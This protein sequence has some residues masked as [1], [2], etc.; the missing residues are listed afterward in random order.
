MDTVID[1]YNLIRQ[2]PAL[3]TIEGRGLEAGREA[4]LDRLFLYKSGG[5]QAMT[6]VF[7]GPENRGYFARGGI[8]VQFSPSADDAVVALAGPG[9]LVVSSDIEVQTDAR[10]RGARVQGAAEFWQR[11]LSAVSR[12]RYRRSQTPRPAFHGTWDKAHWDEDDERESQRRRKRRKR[13]R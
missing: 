9:V 8:R 10:R 7:D 2:V 5:Q 1:G 11:I 12:R 4:L 13:R 6:V 3:L